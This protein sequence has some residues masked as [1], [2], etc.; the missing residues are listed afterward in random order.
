MADE[1]DQNPADNT[2]DT[3]VTSVQNEASESGQKNPKTSSKET[4]TEQTTQKLALAN[5]LNFKPAGL[6]LSPAYIMLAVALII[7][8]PVFFSFMTPSTPSHEA[9]VVFLNAKTNQ[10]DSDNEAAGLKQ[11]SGSAE[12]K[13]PTSS[14][15]NIPK[16]TPKNTPKSTE[17]LQENILTHNESNQDEHSANTDPELVSLSPELSDVKP[18]QNEP[19]TTQAQQLY[20]ESTENSENAIFD[21]DQT[22]TTADANKGLDTETQNESDQVDKPNESNS[23]LANESSELSMIEQTQQSQPTEQP[24][25]KPFVIYNHDFIGDPKKTKLTI[26]VVEMGNNLAKDRDLV[27]KL[28]IETT[29]AVLPTGDIGK[30]SAAAIREKGSEYLLMLPMEPLDYP[31]SNPGPE[32][33]LTNTDDKQNLSVMLNISQGYKEYMGVMPFMGGRFVRSESVHKSFLLNLHIQGC[34]YFETRFTKSLTEELMPESLPYRKAQFDILSEFSAKDVQATLDKILTIL[35]KRQSVVMTVVADS[36]LVTPVLDW[37]HKQLPE[38]V[39]LVPLSEQMELPL[40]PLDSIPL[41]S[42]SWR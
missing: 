2:R 7:T 4:I 18:T 35:N 6:K 1:K 10:N 17:D 20:P 9:A 37:V 33:L 32:L 27:G 30:A 39:E 14:S 13:L 5:L 8:I 21:S 40:D 16:N 41:E 22:L 23:L 12:V 15:K 26:V 19:Q 25:G 3:E 11:F 34:C 28:P 31:L 38:H 42:G 36:N 24:H 29:Y